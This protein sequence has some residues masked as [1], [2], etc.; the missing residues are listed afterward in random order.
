MS[1]VKRYAE[2]RARRDPE[3]AEG[4]ETGYEEL[5]IGVLLR[6]AREQAGLTQEQVADRLST[7]KSAISR[8]ENHAGDIRLSTLERYVEAIGWS[9]S[10]ALRAPNEVSPR[11]GSSTVP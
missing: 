6:Q 2:E 5:K 4:F 3:F 9:V 8:I 11:S 1:D 10:I 7:Q